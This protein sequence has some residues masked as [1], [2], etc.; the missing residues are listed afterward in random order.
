M[1][2]NV[3]TKLLDVE[4]LVDVVCGPD[5][6]RSL[7]HLIDLSDQTQGVVAN[8]LLSIDET[9]QDIVPTRINHHHSAYV[10]IMRGCNNM[11]AFC[12]VP[13]TRGVE[14]SRP[15]ESI[16]HE[17]QHLYEQGIKEVT[18]L[19][20]NVNSYRDT[21]EL[22]PSPGQLSNDGFKSMRTLK[23]HGR[24]FTHLLDELSTRFPYIRFRFTSP[25]PKDFP[26][27][28]LHLIASRD[29]LCKNIHLPVQS[30]STSMLERMRRGY[31][32]EAYLRLIS[33]VRSILPDITI[34]TDIIA[35]FCG[36]TPEAH[37][38]TVTL[39]EEVRFDMA[40]MYAY[41]MR[42]RTHAHRRYVD[43]VPAPVKSERLQEIIATFHRVAQEKNQLMIGREV[44]VLVDG[45]SKR[46]KAKMV[47]RTS[48]N[49]KV[50][51]Q[52]TSK[53]DDVAVGDYVTATVTKGTSLS[54]DGT[55]MSKVAFG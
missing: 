6:Y 10:S 17:M 46:D 51:L 43:D 5:A 19:G 37:R 39:M 24:T 45:P 2:N 41:S 54:F 44:T 1:A 35:G 18:L 26:H 14:R 13:F 34:S 3:K 15:I 50:I 30:G 42:E 33:D 16:V 4:R 40:Y 38:D 32:R 55:A 21:T 28:L 22:T 48:G 52:D 12:V 36:E 20:Q 9:Y 49:Q 47:G 8:T 25:H 29:N 31:A 7:A 23:H 27:E 11:C 53:V